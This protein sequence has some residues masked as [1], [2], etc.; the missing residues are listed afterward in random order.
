[1]LS[2]QV[3]KKCKEI[4]IHSGWSKVAE[5]LWNSGTAFCPAKFSVALDVSVKAP[6]PDWCPYVLEHAL[7]GGGV[8]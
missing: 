5:Q 4:H 6:P 7:A 3:C 1:M 8:C 2:K